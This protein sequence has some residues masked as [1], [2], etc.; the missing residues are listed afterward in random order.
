[1]L[2]NA[3]IRGQ[4]RNH[5][6]MK[7]VTGR[8]NAYRECVRH[9][10]NGYFLE[11]IGHASDKWAASEGFDDVCATLFGSLVVAPL[12][13]VS[14]SA[15]SVL[16]RSR[17]LDGLA[18]EWL[19]VVPRA[20]PASV[21]IMINRDPRSDGG[22]WDHPLRQVSQSDISLRFVRWFDFGELEFRDFRYFLVRVASAS[23]SD[24]VGRAALIECEY[25]DVFLDE[26]AI[27][28]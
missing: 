24:V 23:Q 2:L 28:A 20:T 3:K 17:D 7:D 13:V 10:W 8:F 25:A 18:I 5:P 19:H 9:L 6:F 1:L 27:P 12:G 4:I 22:Y 11:A 16:S 26:S 15:R 21:P 14:A